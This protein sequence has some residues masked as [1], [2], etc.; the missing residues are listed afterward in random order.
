MRPDRLF[1]CHG[2]SLR[3]RRR[4]TRTRTLLRTRTAV[5]PHANRDRCVH[6]GRTEQPELCGA[7]CAGSAV[8][9]DTPWASIRN[10]CALRDFGRYRKASH[11]SP[12]KRWRRH[13]MRDHAKASTQASRADRRIAAHNR[14]ASGSECRL[15]YTLSLIRERRHVREI[16]AGV[17]FRPP[18]GDSKVS[19]SPVHP[20][21]FTI[22]VGDAAV[23]EWFEIAD[24]KRERHTSSFDISRLPLIRD[25]FTSHWEQSRT[26]AWTLRQRAS[27]DGRLAGWNRRAIRH[28][29]R[30][31]SVSVHHGELVA[32]IA[33]AAA[34]FSAS[35][36]PSLLRPP[37]NPRR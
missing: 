1:D 16:W 32:T 11:R 6:R 10:C 12:W 31:A 7:R 37:R 15:G 14:N 24:R 35:R 25:R 20:P 17:P 34:A 36:W 22:A 26:R 21:C 8:H 4:G 30:N 29:R 5:F 33:P 28:Q 9:P 13:R 3:I 27:R 19:N 2:G 18:S 23:R